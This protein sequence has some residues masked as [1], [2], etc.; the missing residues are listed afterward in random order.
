M[1][2]ARAILLLLLT[3]PLALAQDDDKGLSD[4]QD[5]KLASWK[6]SAELRL[7]DKDGPYVALPVPSALF[8]KAQD[9]LH[10]VRI[11]DAQGTRIPYVRRVLN[12]KSEPTPI[13]IKRQFNAGPSAK[14]KIYEMSIE[15]GDVPA[16]GHNDIEIETT[17]RQFRRKVEVLGDTSDKFANP[18]QLLDKNAYLIHFD[19]DNRLVEVRRFRYDFK[20]FRF[21]QVRVHA[22]PSEEETP[23]ITRVTVR[24]TVVQAGEYVTEPADLGERDLVRGQGGPGSA[25]LIT[26]PNRMPVEKVT[27]QA[28]GRPR[29][30]PIEL[31]IAEPDQPPTPITLRDW[32]WRNVKQA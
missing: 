30:G 11:A 5:P 4:E 26:L 27:L 3:A 6:W 10:D 12:E 21:L 18:Q 13:D 14:A 24:R 9:Y 16:P 31:Q 23:K 8:G 1:N 32:R 15:L 17:G 29:A 20:Q 28:V 2:N 22:D 7:P 25:W 19:V